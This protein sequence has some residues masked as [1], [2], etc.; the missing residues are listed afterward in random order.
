MKLSLFVPTIRFLTLSLLSQSD[1]FS[2]DLYRAHWREKK[3]VPSFHCNSIIG[4]LYDDVVDAIKRNELALTEY[5]AEAP[6]SLAGRKFDKYGQILSVLAPGQDLKT[7]LAKVYNPGIVL[8]LGYAQPDRNLQSFARKE[9]LNYDSQ[10]ATIMNSH[11]ILSEG[12]VWTGC[13]H[14][15]HKE[16]MRR[17]HEVSQQVVRECRNM[18]ATHR[19]RFFREVTRICLIASHKKQ[20]EETSRRECTASF[21]VEASVSTANSSSVNAGGNAGGGGNDMNDE[22]NVVTWIHEVTTGGTDMPYHQLLDAELARRTASEL[23]AAYYMATYDPNSRCSVDNTVF[24]SFPWIVSDVIAL[25]MS[26]KPDAST[27]PP[28]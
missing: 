20:Q 21:M 4:K 24:F 1:G 9:R 27:R 11:G 5:I 17:Q 16:N 15:Y 6:F 7:N 2:L 19:D 26:P 28:R 12:E 22:E 18:R 23:A 3:H 14:K 8:L 25:G 13:I 10:L